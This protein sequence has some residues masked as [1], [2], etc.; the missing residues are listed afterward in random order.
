MAWLEATGKSGMKVVERDSTHNY[1]Y[2]KII[3][4]IGAYLNGRL[5]NWM[6]KY[7]RSITAMPGPEKLR[8]LRQMMN[9]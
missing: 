6:I 9:I 8:G 1:R 7:T 3:H 2:R 4:L 5:F